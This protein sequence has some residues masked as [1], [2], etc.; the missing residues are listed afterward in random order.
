MV[1]SPLITFAAYA[2]VRLVSG[3]GSFTVVKATT[4]LSILSLMNTPARPLLFTIPFGLQ[5]VQSFKRIQNFLQ[6]NEHPQSMAKSHEIAEKALQPC[7]EQGKGPPVAIPAIHAKSVTFGWE[8]DAPPVV[9]LANACFEKGS[10]TAITEPIGC[11]KSKLLKGL[12]SETACM[13]ESLQAV[14]GAVS[15]CGQTPR[16]FEGTIRENI[17]GESDFDAL[18]YKEVICSCELD[19][20]LTRMSG[21]DASMVGSKGLS[22]SGGQRQRIVSVHLTVRFLIR[23]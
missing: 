5:A 10:F 21:G 12:L 6:L 16:I 19:F 14:T 2:I 3:E 7:P 4:C 11:R 23:D 13:E 15:Y 20:D 17:I 18:W 8:T 1:L 9:Y 22:I